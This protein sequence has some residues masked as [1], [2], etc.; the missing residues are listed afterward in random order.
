MSRLS[1][2]FIRD[3]LQ[4]KLLI[5]YILSHLDQ[6]ADLPELTDLVLCDEG[7]DYFSFTD[8][9]SELVE[10]GHV[11]HADNLYAIT[12]KG[13]EHLQVCESNLP[14]SVRMKCDKNTEAVNRGK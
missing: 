2:G 11:A 9:L 6:A 4:L 3:K 1:P 10:T 13:R 12:S 5:L 14:Y 8:A 7:V